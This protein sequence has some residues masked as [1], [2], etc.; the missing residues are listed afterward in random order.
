[1][2]SSDLYINCHVSQS[3]DILHKSIEMSLLALVKMSYSLAPF[4]DNFMLDVN[5]PR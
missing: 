1:M 5:L 3:L 4:G 2:Y